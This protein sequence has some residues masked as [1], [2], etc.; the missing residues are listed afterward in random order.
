MA[1]H[2]Y[3]FYKSPDGII[4]PWIPI[5]ITNP[6]NNRH[7]G[8]MALLDTG[9]D[10]CVFPKAVAVLLGLD[11]KGDALSSE[12]MQ[13]LAEQKIEVWKHTFR[14][15]LQSPDKKS[16]SWKGRETIIACVEHDNIPPILGFSNFMCHFKITFNHATKRIMIDDHPKV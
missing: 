7:I 8:L 2:V 16:I 15:D 13:G 9:A 3:P 4:R 6:A 5:I 14:I 10:H 11:L 1:V 12:V